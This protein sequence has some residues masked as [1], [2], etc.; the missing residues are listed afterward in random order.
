MPN[1]W[2]T[3]N[4]RQISLIS[5]LAKKVEVV[6]LLKLQKKLFF[7]LTGFFTFD[8]TKI[9][10]QPLIHPQF[11]PRLSNTLLVKVDP[12]NYSCQ[13]QKIEIIC[14]PLHTKGRV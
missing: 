10:C 6:D 5:C 9:A 2:Y 3:Q 4:F 8:D 14:V 1:S 11:S 7:C 12:N 13:T